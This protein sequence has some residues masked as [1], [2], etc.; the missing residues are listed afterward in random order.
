MAHTCNLS[1]SRDRGR[2]RG[3]CHK[4]EARPDLYSKFQDRLVL[5]EQKLMNKITEMVKV[6]FVVLS[7]ISLM[8]T[9]TT[10]GKYVQQCSYVMNVCICPFGYD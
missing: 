9:L 8:H 5:K 1:S 7:Q 4:F 6:S 10:E 3:N 2:G